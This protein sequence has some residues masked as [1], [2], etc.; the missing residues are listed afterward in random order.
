MVDNFPN[1]GDPTGES[2]NRKEVSQPDSPRPIE[3]G[4]VSIG[5]PEA[6]GVM[7]GHAQLEGCVLCIRHLPFSHLTANLAEKSPDFGFL[8]RQS[9]RRL[10]IF[11]TSEMRRENLKIGG[12]FLSQILPVRKRDG[13]C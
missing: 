13:V 4:T 8:R 6:K 11:P 5:R 12:K 2:E 7:A 1:I 9:G 3:K 10:K